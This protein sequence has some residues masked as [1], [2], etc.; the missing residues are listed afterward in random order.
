MTGAAR[1]LVAGRAQGEV[2]KLSEPLNAWGGLDPETGII[3]HHSHPQ[4]GESLAGR[5]LVMQ[6]SRGSGTNAQ[7]FA[8]AWA[9]GN[10]PLGV[11][12]GAPDYVLCVGAVVTNELYGIACPVVVIEPD[13]YGALNHGDHVTVV[14]DDIK[15]T[16]VARD[17]RVDG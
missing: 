13:A 15:A 1:T 16:V 2:L 3:V 12:L 14:A 9:N 7:V 6:E 5:M 4:R 10:G 11:V 8:Q 17:A